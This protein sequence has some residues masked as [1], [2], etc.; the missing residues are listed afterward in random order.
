MCDQQ[1]TDGGEQTCVYRMALEEIDK[2]DTSEFRTVT[3]GLMTTHHRVVHGGDV[4]NHIAGIV[5]PVL[6]GTDAK[7]EPLSAQAQRS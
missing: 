3:T 4:L 5:N 7:G 1:A 6:H 2:I